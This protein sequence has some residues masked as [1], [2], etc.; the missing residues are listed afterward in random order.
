MARTALARR[1]A[2]LRRRGCRIVFTNGCFD[3]I[4]AGHVRYL[5]RA[6]CLGDFLVVGVNT[7]A[8]VRRLKGPGRPV[9]SLSERLT[10]LGGLEA[11][12][13]V[14]PFGEDTPE[15][16]IRALNPDVLVKGAD[17][18]L[19]RIVGRRQVSARGGVVRRI[20]LQSPTT[21]SKIIRRILSRQQSR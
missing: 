18:P 8:S 6:R 21:T 1:L 7:D 10:V 19:G 16:L 13:F 2:R 9:L 20:A 5:E 3:L 12:D 11:V 4:H 14:L 15:A 17:W